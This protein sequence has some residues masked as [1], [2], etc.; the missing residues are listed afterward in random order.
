MATLTLGACV[1]CET[2]L[3]TRALYCS[4]AC[5]WL[6]RKR[7]DGIPCTVCGEPT[8]WTKR[9]GKEAVTHKACGRSA[10]GTVSSYQRGCRCHRCT[11]AKRLNSREY[12][13][14]NYSGGRRGGGLITRTCRACGVDFNPRSN[15]VLCSPECRKA[16][17]G[18]YG[19]HRSRATYW[20]VE[21]ESVDRLAVFERDNWTCG[22]CELPVDRGLKYPDPGYPTLDHITP[23]SLGG[24]HVYGNLQLAHFYCNTVKGNRIEAEAC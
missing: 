13:Q 4:Q 11:E 7:R 22:I 6:A 20:G 18:R 19:D 15:Q 2:P 12:W 14:Q 21:F 1:E 10:C 9:S 24:G 5:K 16:E 3:H 17:L 8:G 23:M